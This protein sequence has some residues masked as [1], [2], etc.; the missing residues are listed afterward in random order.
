MLRIVN[1]ML[2]VAALLFLL[3]HTVL[4]QNANAE[5]DATIAKA[6]TQTLVMVNQ[7]SPSFDKMIEAFTQK[8]GIKVDATVAR[9]TSFCR[10]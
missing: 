8:F 9:P 5:W 10:G 2:S 4:A 3:P 1:G 7:G 6:K